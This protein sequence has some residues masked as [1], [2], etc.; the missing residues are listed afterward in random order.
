MASPVFNMA[1]QL[2]RL[3]KAELLADAMADSGVTADTLLD[4]PPGV[5]ELATR[6]VSLQEGRVVGPPSEA[7]QALVHSLLVQREKPSDLGPHLLDGI[8]LRG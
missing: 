4:M 1:E 2:A 3:R 7:T 5:W 6:V 8:G